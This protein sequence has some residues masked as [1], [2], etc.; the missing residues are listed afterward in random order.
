MKRIYRKSK[1]CLSCLPFYEQIDKHK[2]YVKYIISGGTAATTDLALLYVLTEFFNMH[3]LLS[4]SIAFIIAFFI[5]FF[6]QKFWTFRDNNREKIYKQMSLYLFVCVT[7]LFIN[8]GGMYFLVDKFNI[9]YMVAQVIMGGLIAIFSFLIYRSF[10]FNNHDAITEKKN[11]L[12]AT[13]IF[14]PDIGGPATYVKTLCDEL[15]EKGFN[16]KVVTY[17]DKNSKLNHSIKIQN[18]KFKIFKINKNRNLVIR[19]FNYF[20]RV[21]KLLNWANIVYVQGPVSEG[22]PSWL[23]CK[24]RRKKYILKIVGDYGW[25]QGTQ[26]FGVNDLLDEFQN[27]KYNNS[28]ERIRKIQKLVAR[29]AEK[30]ITPSEYLKNIVKKWGISDDK[31]KVIYNCVDPSHSTG[32][33]KEEIKKELCLSGDIILSA[34]RLVPWKGFELLIDLM[35]ELLKANPDFKLIIAGEGPEF[36]NLSLKIKN[37]ELEKFIKLIGKVEHEK[38]LKYMKAS[39]IF[40]LNTGYEGLSHVIIEAMQVGLPVITT[41]VGGNPEVVKNGENGLLV[42]YNNKEEI[43]N[44]ILKLDKDVELKNKLVNNAKDNFGKFSKERMISEVIEFLR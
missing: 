2:I 14:P 7:N 44:A 17:F 11:I 5:S 42:E 18:S 10:I 29:G 4:A 9:M 43:K 22:L 36:E 38:L 32:R 41:N 33:S 30:I 23:A 27:K 21:L 3:Y 34:G 8:T 35:P 19:Y 40:M 15:P 16:V 13:G 1:K 20:L 12:I 31:I 28:V 24:L 6:L 39:D 37:L 26:R 25:E